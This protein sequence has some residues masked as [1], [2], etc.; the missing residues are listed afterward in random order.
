MSSVFDPSKLNLDPNKPSEPKKT[1]KVSESLGV[2][3]PKTTP[4]KPAATPTAELKSTPVVDPLGSVEIKPDP[5][6]TK[7]APVEKSPSVK[8]DNSKPELADKKSPIAQEKA[9]TLPEE[10][11]EK[12]IIDINLKSLDDMILLL[13]DNQYDFATIVPNED[14]VK[15]SFRKDKIEKEV[16]YIKFPTYNTIL[17]Q[18]K[19]AA[20]LKV[21]ISQSDQEGK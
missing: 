2:Q 18:I 8:E 1:E 5:T 7:P 11:Q 13:N 3:K 9:P 17:V 15:V 20:K 10:P 14:E 19:Q 4:A 16:K 21:E 6:P 12:R